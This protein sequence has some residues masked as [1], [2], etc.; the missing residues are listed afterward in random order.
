MTVLGVV[1]GGRYRNGGSTWVKET[2]DMG[3]D[4]KGK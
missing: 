4:D 2:G 3:E 1:E